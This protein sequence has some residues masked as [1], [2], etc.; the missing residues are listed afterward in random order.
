MGFK[1]PTW[2]DAIGAAAG[3]IPRIIKYFKDKARVNEIK[4]IND[5]VD[6]GDTKYVD[7]VMRKIK[8]TYNDK[9]DANS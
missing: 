2:G 8:K 5:A 3:S 7:G 4:K 6:S 1:I 9:R